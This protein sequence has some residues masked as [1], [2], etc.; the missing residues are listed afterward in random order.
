MVFITI[1]DSN[2]SVVRAFTRLARQMIRVSSKTMLTLMCDTK[3]LRGRHG[4]NRMV[5][6]LKATDA[7]TDVVRLNLDQGE[8]Y[9]II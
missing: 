8:V 1:D 9:N 2:D 4:R 3:M 5:V 6:G 7:I